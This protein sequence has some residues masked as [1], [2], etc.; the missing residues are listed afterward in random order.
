MGQEDAGGEGGPRP[1]SQPAEQ[2]VDQPGVEQMQENVGEMVAP[3]VEPAEPVVEGESQSYQGTVVVAVPAEEM[4]VVGE[5]PRPGGKIPDEDIADDQRLVVPEEGVGED[6]KVERPGQ[7]GQADENNQFSFYP[8]KHRSSPVISL[9]CFF[10]LGVPPAL[11]II[12]YSF[13]LPTIL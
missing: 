4:K 12:F 8:F 11:N 2:A 5:E 13:P 10:A 7:D 6:G 9:L 3:G 1:G